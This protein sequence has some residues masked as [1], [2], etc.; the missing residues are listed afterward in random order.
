MHEDTWH[1]YSGEKTAEIVDSYL[2]TWR[3]SSNLL[4]NAGCGIY[5][6]NIQ[7]WLELSF[8]LFVTPIRNHPN[9]VC[10]S[11]EQLP[12]VN[13]CFGGIVCVG[14]VLGYCDPA[15]AIAEFSRVLV[16]GGIL[17]CDFGNSSSLRYWLKSSYDR[18]ADIVTEQYNGT[19]E[20]TWIYDPKYIKSL[21][22]MNGFRIVKSKGIHTWSSLLCRLGLSINSAIFLQR[23]LDWLR[24]P[25]SWAALRTIVAAKIEAG[26]QEERIASLRLACPPQDSKRPQP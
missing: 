8:D 25:T 1:T 2:K 11:A 18:S 21:L 6:I 16:P 9:S 13:S 24:L 17:I 22:K 5:R 23:R 19:P 14:E 15:R 26:T 20:R 4:L 3:S 10:G 12:F 7:G